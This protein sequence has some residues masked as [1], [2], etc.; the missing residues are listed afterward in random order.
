MRKFAYSLTAGAIVVLTM[1]G[2]STQK[3][4]AGTRWWH[5]FN[6]RYNIYYNGKQAF[7]EGH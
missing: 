2:C 5:S 1:V 4:T 7:L 6:A 3:N